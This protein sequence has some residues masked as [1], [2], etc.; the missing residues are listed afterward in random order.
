MLRQIL[1]ILADGQFHS[2]EELGKRLGVSRAAVWKQL[3]KLDE[4]NIPY[5]SIRGKGYRLPEP[6]E[7]LSLTEIERQLSQRLDKLEVLLDVASTNTYLF[8]QSSDYMGQRYAVLAEK[9]SAGKGRRG[10]LWVSPFGKSIYLS[11]LTTF[12]GGIASLE[13]LSLMVAIA[14]ERALVSLGVE[15]IGLKW[16]NDVYA[17]GKKL[18]GILLEV[19]GEY[20]SHCQVVIG[21]GLNLALNEKDAA[22]IEQPWVELRSLKPE[23]SRN[24]V[25]AALLDELLKVVDEFQQDGFA[26]YQQYWTERDIYH[27]QSVR[28]LSGSKE[29]LGI[30]K[31]VNRKGELMLKTE[32]GMEVLN[33][34]E[35]S[36]RTAN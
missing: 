27:N 19:N 13:G 7:L 26:P 20:S 5:S 28:I 34:G 25:A 21:V 2:G 12:A 23:L 11:L 35:V 4:L 9:Q 10:R 15:G 6:I 32:L 1:S 16:P 33:A 31:G 14:V 36:V 18:A 3:K 22:E 30:I 24:Q 29:K 17:Q 8:Q